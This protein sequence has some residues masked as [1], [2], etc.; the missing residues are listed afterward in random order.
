MPFDGH[1]F[2]IETQHDL[3]TPRGRLLYLRD[4]VVPR[5]TSKNLHMDNIWCG[6]AGCL[7]GHAQ[8]DANLVAAGLGAQSYISFDSV[9]EGTGARTFYDLTDKQAWHIFGESDVYGCVSPTHAELTEHI[10]DVLD[11]RV[12]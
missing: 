12:S 9:T 6:T 3:T 4:V 11:G 2:R 7:H 10:N 5:T 8:R 1:N